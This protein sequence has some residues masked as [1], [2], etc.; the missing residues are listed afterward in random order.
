MLASRSAIELALLAMLAGAAEEIVFRGVLQAWLMES[1]TSGVALLV[2]SAVFGLAHFM[3]RVYALL[4]AM[5]GLYL[6]CL[7]CFRATFSHRS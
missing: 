3:T 2:A 1:D 7:F 6:G 5:A 4:A